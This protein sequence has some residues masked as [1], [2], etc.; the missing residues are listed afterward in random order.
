M[1]QKWSSVAVNI[2]GRKITRQYLVADGR[3]QTTH[4]LCLLRPQY[5][6]TNLQEMSLKWEHVNDPIW[7][8]EVTVSKVQTWKHR[9]VSSNNKSEKGGVRQGKRGKTLRE[10]AMY[11]L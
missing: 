4:E 9:T 11:Q 6:T 10:K 2:T 8:R 1:I 3:T 5:L 7:G